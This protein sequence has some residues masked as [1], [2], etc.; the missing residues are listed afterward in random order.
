VPPGVK[1][2]GLLVDRA[3]FDHLLLDAAQKAGVR[4]IQPARARAAR[5][6]DGW[7]IIAEAATPVRIGARWLIDAAGRGGC[8][9][10]RRVPFGPRTLALWAHMSVDACT[11]TR[12][13]A[14]PEGWIWAAPVA[15][16]TLSLIMFCDADFLRFS[17]GELLENF[18]RRR[19]A[20]TT[21]FTNLAEARFARPPTVHNATC[22][23]ASA[24]AGNRYVKVGEAN[25]CVDPLSS[26]GVEKA[27]QTALHG[28]LVAHTIMT[29][30]E[31]AG[32]CAQF[33]RERQQEAVAQH[34]AWMS[35]YYGEVR[36]HAGEPFWKARSST[37]Q[38]PT[39]RQVA[40]AP[41]E[42]SLD[43]RVSLSRDVV[44]T[45]EP[46][47]VGDHIELR[48][49][50]RS[51]RLPRSLVFLDGF[52]IVP[53]IRRIT[54]CKTFREILIEWSKMIGSP[55]AARLAQWLWDHGIL[56]SSEWSGETKGM[57]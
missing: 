32:I 51:A 6:R 31:R 13:E 55:K 21:L 42:A 12:I 37:P 19:L 41:A 47:I 16:K 49:G 8:V 44:I 56:S 34:T 33:H 20:A 29:H 22:S 27:V 7:H 17:P 30:P 57:G 15:P 3:A 54:L 35:W 26:T 50:L 52:E 48:P 1:A 25:Y 5:A 10:G 23:F 11:G 4:V 43:L 18:L 36:R 24:P 14:L 45:E 46:C 40:V 9:Y 28:A 38:A 39:G 53:L 2:N